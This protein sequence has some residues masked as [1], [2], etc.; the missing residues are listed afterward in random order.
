MIAGC[1][2]CS[3]ACSTT[4]AGLPGI[5]PGSRR[6]P[7]RHG[8]RLVP[9]LLARERRRAGVRH[10]RGSPRPGRPEPQQPRGAELR[11]RR[12]AT[13]AGAGGGR[14]APRRR[15]CRV[16]PVQGLRAA[17]YAVPSRFRAAVVARV[18]AR[19]PGAYLVGEVIHGTYA[20][21]VTDTGLDTVTQYE[22]W[23]IGW[24]P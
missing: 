13:L 7:Q 22:L 16:V 3:T 5:P 17:P 21:A 15:P 8:S 2:S 19:H 12:D 9:A 18:R 4:S 24:S 10:L 20:A 14:L 23:R 11:R 1:G 6:R